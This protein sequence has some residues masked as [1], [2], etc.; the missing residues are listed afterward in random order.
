MHM[1]PAERA[2]LTLNTAFA[3]EHQASEQQRI[4]ILSCTN[5]NVTTAYF[6][7]ELHILRRSGDEKSVVQ[8]R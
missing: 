4:N 7:L 5:V 8:S 6:H 1:M 2:R 3:A